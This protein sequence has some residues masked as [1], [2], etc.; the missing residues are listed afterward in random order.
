MVE[1]KLIG[2]VSCY[3]NSVVNPDSKVGAVLMCVGYDKL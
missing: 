2:G 1:A 3:R